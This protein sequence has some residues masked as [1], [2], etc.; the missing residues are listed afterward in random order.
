MYRILITSLFFFFVLGSSGQT[1]IIIH[2]NTTQHDKDKDRKKQNTKVNK[3][4]IKD[5]AT[6][7]FGAGES[8]IKFN[9]SPLFR[10]DYCLSFEKKVT[11]LFSVE[12]TGGV[13]YSDALFDE[14]GNFLNYRPYNMTSF[15]RQRGVG[16]SV[17]IAARNYF[18]SADEE[19]EGPYVALEAMF[20]RYN[21]T[22][23][24]NYT[25]L[26]VKEFNDHRE[27][28]G[29]VGWQGTSWNDVTTFDIAAG[30]GY[31]MHVRDY[32]GYTDNYSYYNDKLMRG[33]KNYL[34]FLINFKIGFLLDY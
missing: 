9:I 14:I 32:V 6:S 19:I 33:Q 25:P 30:I 21:S 16:P 20:R 7:F 1:K 5:G 34:V 17:K 10:G 15:N 2:E 11:P 4:R 8:S 24:A 27:I 23:Y 28:R 22:A 3:G 18:D 26:P 12:L 13:T 29:L 31:R